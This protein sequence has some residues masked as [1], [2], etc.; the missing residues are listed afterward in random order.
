VL[1]V[2]SVYSCS[3]RGEIKQFFR[4]IRHKEK[5]LPR[6]TDSQPGKS[7]S[8][9]NKQTTSS[10]AS[11]RAGAET[12]TKTSSGIKT[13]GQG[14]E[15]RADGGCQSEDAA[16]PYINKKLKNRRNE[17]KRQHYGKRK[18]C[19]ATYAKAGTEEGI[20]NNLGNARKNF[21]KRN[22]LIRKSPSR[23]ERTVAGNQEENNTEGEEE[24]RILLPI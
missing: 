4:A 16:K 12:A 7:S 23:M 19:R 14:G 5:E 21:L 2:F 17:K 24:E 20:E 9:K 10:P 11:R 22:P 13:T 18:G 1:T 3:G 15:E 8:K 6:D